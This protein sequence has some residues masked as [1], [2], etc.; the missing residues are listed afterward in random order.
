MKKSLL[1][2]AFIIIWLSPVNATDKLTTYVNPFLGSATLWEKKDLHYD[3]KR[4]ARTWGGETFPGSALPNAMIQLTP[5]TMFHSGSGYQ[6]EDKQ[7]FGFAHT[8]KGHWNLLHLPILAV[9]GDRINPD[10]YASSF[11]H[12]NES[13]HPGY[14]QVYLERYDI[15]AEMTSTLRCGFHKYTF[16]E[17]D[18]K[19]LIVDMGQTN[20][21]VKEWTIQKINDN[22]FA[23]YQ[24]AEGKI[25]FYAVSNYPITQVEQQQGNEHVVSVIDFKNLKDNHPLELKIGFS[26][27]SI[28]GAK[29]N[30]EKEMLNKSFEEVENEADKT[31]NQLL[32][33]IQ[34]DGGTLKQKQLFYSCLYRSFLW[35]CLRSDVNKD[36]YDESGHV[37]NNG[38][39][40]YTLPSFW[41]DYRNKLTLLGLVQPEVAV[42]VIKS[43]I[44]KG[45]KSNGY[46]PTFFHGDHASTFI[47]GS[48]LRGLKNFDLKRAYQLILKNATVPGKGG[49]PYLDEYL[50]QG[51]IAEKDTTNVPFYDEYKASVTKTLEYAYD[52]YATAQVAKI[53]GDT[54]NYK[55]LMKH[56]QNYKNVFDP[57]TG[58]FRGRIANGSFIKDFDPYYPYFAYMYRESNAWNNLFFA[59]HDING[60]LKLYPSKKAVEDKLDSLFSEPWRAYE[61]EN[62]TGFIGNYCHGNQPGHS[63]PYTYYFVGRQDKAQCILDS[64]MNHYYDMGADHL[65]LAGMDDAGEM[66]SWFV[67]NAIGLYTLSPADPKYIVTVP[68]F[69]KILFKMNNGK[70]LT[71]QKQGNS[72]T[73]K[74]IL[75]GGKRI[76]GWFISD[77]QIK[78]GQELTIQT[79]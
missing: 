9:T 28:D 42:D 14:Y 22:V 37:V 8:S 73:I 36:Y 44:D 40:Y 47:A 33:K 55:L 56:S 25:Y 68:L 53:L 52:D 41:D 15:N 3:R 43:I 18:R 7:I 26:F 50:K 58:F 70:T 63:I 46:M 31:W 17:N 21:K 11:S 72:R 6:Y 75:Y 23:G 79:K 49:R 59:P 20:N 32:E 77:D 64:I 51:W 34:V 65:A 66:S 45:E 60:M 2:I 5:V 69:D 30:L 27:V 54:K 13:A 24:N 67:F 12:S 71:I 35:P 39:D 29:A 10:D 4:K 38:F 61:V 48:Y 76:Q 19:R 16:K 74:N 57:S 1:T 78:K 62:L